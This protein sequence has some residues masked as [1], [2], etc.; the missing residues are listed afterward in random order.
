MTSCQHII[1]SIIIILFCYLVIIAAINTYLCNNHHILQD[2]ITN[3]THINLDYK[4]QYQDHLLIQTCGEYLTSDYKILISN[5]K[6]GLISALSFY[7]PFLSPIL[8]GTSIYTDRSNYVKLTDKNSKASSF[9]INSIN[10]DNRYIRYGDQISIKEN[11]TNMFIN[12]INISTMISNPVIIT[13]TSPIKQNNEIVCYGDPYYLTYNGKNLGYKVFKS[14]TYISGDTEHSTLFYFKPL[15]TSY[16]KNIIFPNIYEGVIPIKETLKI[17]TYNIWMLPN[18]LTN[19]INV[20]H[21]K[22][23]RILEI[24]RVL[25]EIDADIIVLTEAFDDKVRDTIIL[26]LRQHGNYFFETQC[27]GQLNGLIN[28]GIIIISKIQILDTNYHIYTNSYQDDKIANKGVIYIKI[29]HNHKFIHIFGTH[30]QAWDSFSAVEARKKQIIEL[31]TFADSIPYKHNNELTI[32]A[33]DF[34][35]DR[36]SDDY[37]YLLDT[38]E[39]DNILPVTDKFTINPDTNKL[40]DGKTISNSNKHELIDY[41]FYGKNKIP[42]IISSDILEVKS[43]PYKYNNQI[44]NDLSDHYPVVAEILIN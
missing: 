20:S 2:I 13:I 3:P 5:K 34:N 16:M 28:G 44:Y 9:I 15:Y 31:K 38:L 25:L 22:Q 40:A 1:G 19:T 17:V 11:K 10:S 42:K 18:I 41:I 30:L 27:I 21:S 7:N 4:V 26:E 8:I 32:F 37:S 23:E 36:Y 14:N 43:K 6:A 12:P 29:E 35:I 39:V 33:G 24:I